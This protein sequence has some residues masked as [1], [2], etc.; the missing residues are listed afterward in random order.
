M[1]ILPFLLMDRNIAFQLSSRRLGLLP[2]S[3]SSS[4]H[5]SAIEAHPAALV[6]IESASPATELLPISIESASLVAK[7][8]ATTMVLVVQPPPLCS[9]QPP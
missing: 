5:W 8:L 6:P 9:S 2:P 4:A 1:T 7:I 3:P